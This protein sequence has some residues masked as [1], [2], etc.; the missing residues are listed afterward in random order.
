MVVTSD[1]RNGVVVNEPIVWTR[2]VHARCEYESIDST[3]GVLNCL[4]EE[5]CRKEGDLRVRKSMRKMSTAVVVLPY[6]QCALVR[7]KSGFL[8]SFTLPVR[9]NN[10]APVLSDRQLTASMRKPIEHRWQ[11]QKPID[12]RS[13]KANNKATVR[14]ASSTKQ[15]CRGWSCDK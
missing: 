6:V 9:I 15:E 13:R 7:P 2:R 10:K 1:D 8:R 5:R 11:S 3:R 12:M 14:G 4:V